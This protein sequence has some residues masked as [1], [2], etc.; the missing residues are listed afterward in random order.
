MKIKSTNEKGVYITKLPFSQFEICRKVLVEYLA[1]A[2]REQVAEH[3]LELF[4]AYAMMHMEFDCSEF[5][6]RF[7]EICK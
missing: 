5:Y 4:D 6:M 3:F 1:T 7:R 2:P